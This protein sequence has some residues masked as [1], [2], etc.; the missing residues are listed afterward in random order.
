MR[1]FE[2]FY[3]KPH[4]SW[5]APLQLIKNQSYIRG[6]NQSYLTGFKDSTKPHRWG[7]VKPLKATIYNS[8]FYSSAVGRP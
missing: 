7:F 3:M 1:G 5:G 4:M 8:D 2:G 6:F